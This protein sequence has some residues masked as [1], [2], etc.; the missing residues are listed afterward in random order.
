MT[1]PKS[2][3]C[4]EAIRTRAAEALRAAA[5]QGLLTQGIARIMGIT[6]RSLWVAMW[7]A[8]RDGEFG[9]WPD[10]HGRCANRRRYWL[11][12]FRPAKCPPPSGEQAFEGGH[13]SVRKPPH[14]LGL[15]STRKP[16]AADLAGMRAAP[17]LVVTV[18]PSCP[19]DMRYQVDPSTRVLG[20]FAT[21]GAGK[22]LDG[23]A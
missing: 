14:K 3:P 4:V 20:G 17:G 13:K 10:P 2:G 18:C 9:W 15:P 11:A 23:T 21:M 5:H 8:V 6:Q 1:Q 22:Y 12:E 7:Y 19:I 16:T